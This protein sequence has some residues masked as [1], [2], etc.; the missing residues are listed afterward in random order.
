MS[1]PF[2]LLQPGQKFKMHPSCGIP[3]VWEVLRVTPSSA[4]VRCLAKE[5]VVIPGV[6]DDQVAKADF[7]RPGRPIQ[8][9]AHSQVVLLKEE[10]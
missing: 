7:W 3:Y 1:E 8:I 10:P 9:S 5:H 6:L 2:P 4:T